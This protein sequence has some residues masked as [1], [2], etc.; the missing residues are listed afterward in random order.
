MRTTEVLPDLVIKELSE[1]SWADRPTDDWKIV[2]CPLKDETHAAQLLGWVE[3]N[4]IGLVRV[5][6]HRASYDGIGEAWPLG[7]YGSEGAR[8]ASDTGMRFGEPNSY[9][10]DL[11]GFLFAD[12]AEAQ[13]FSA[14]FA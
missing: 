13:L 2:L 14:L 9:H 3:C 5:W 10:T 11:F 7:G 6:V 12:A 1:R 8:P 4:T